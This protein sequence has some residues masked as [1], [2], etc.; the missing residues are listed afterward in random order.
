M[1]TVLRQCITAVRCL[2]FHKPAKTVLNSFVPAVSIFRSGSSSGAVSK[3]SSR[4]LQCLNEE[5]RLEK[6]NHGQEKIQVQ[7]DANSAIEVMQ[8]DDMEDGGEPLFVPT[9]TVTVS[10]P[11]TSV[12]FDCSFD[13]S[14][15]YEEGS[16]WEYMH[17]D[18][19]TVLPDDNAT[20]E[21]IYSAEAENLNEEL[22]SSLVDYLKERGINEKFATD[23]FRFYTAFEHKR[24]IHDFLKPLKSFIQN[25]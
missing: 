1:A 7:L 11:G 5:I 20:M 9:F 22:Y 14:G 17:I 18:S 6:K 24:Y 8:D 3:A 19:I 23:I 21:H 2:K 15:S 13:E 4:L 16:E 25:N 10:K 12:Q